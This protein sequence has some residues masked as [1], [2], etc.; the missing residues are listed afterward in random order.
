[1][2]NAHCLYNA[3]R[4]GR[5]NVMKSGWA[6][7]SRGLLFQGA[8]YFQGPPTFASSC[9]LLSSMTSKSSF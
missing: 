1:M 3:D 8:S 6:T 5:R 7:L 9:W 4:H 2:L